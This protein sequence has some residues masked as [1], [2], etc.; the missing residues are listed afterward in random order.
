MQNTIFNSRTL[1]FMSF[2]LIVALLCLARYLQVYDGMNPCP[3]CS[4]QRIMMAALG[5]IFFFGAALTLKK[6][7]R[8]LIASFAFLIALCG[9]FLSGRQV[10]LQHFPNTNA[11]DCGVSLH[12]LFQVLPFD[13]AIKKILTGGVECSQVSW[14]FL[15]LSLAEWSLLFFI[16]FS[17][18]GLFQLM[19]AK[20]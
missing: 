6:I 16:L 8:I 9:A 19:C 20:I 7:G 18:I 11:A 17:F 4:L 15:Q 10:W 2:I 3:L 12:Y 14:E 5:V 13:Q 1:Y